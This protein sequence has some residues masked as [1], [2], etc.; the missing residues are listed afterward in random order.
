[1]TTWT[2]TGGRVQLLAGVSV[3]GCA[4]L[5]KGVVVTRRVQL[6]M[7]VAVSGCVFTLISLMRSKR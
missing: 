5:V 2:H 4:Q 1:M 3:S 6:V 7:G